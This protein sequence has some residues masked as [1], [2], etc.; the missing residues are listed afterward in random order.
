MQHARFPTQWSGETSHAAKVLRA[1]GLSRITTMQHILLATD[2]SDC[3][4]RPADVAADIARATGAKLSIVTVGGNAYADDSGALAEAQR[5]EQD[6]GDPKQILASTK[7]RC[8]RAGVS[9]VRVQLEKGDPAEVI[10]ESARREKVDAI[11]MGRR[12]HG[13][14]SQKVSSLAPCI[15]I[16]VPCP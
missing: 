13:F 11:V 8:E 3:A 15:V 1:L 5:N 7:E 6:S 2:G 16:V 12:G 14:V 4:S 10:I 9:D